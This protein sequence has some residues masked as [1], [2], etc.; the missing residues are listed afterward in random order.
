MNNRAVT[1]LICAFLCFGCSKNEGSLFSNPGPE[2]TGVD[3]ENTLTE[4]DELNILDYLYLYNGGGVAVG[5]INN[6]DLPDIFLTGN[7]VKNKLYLN[8][9]ELQFEDISDTAGIGGNSSWNTGAVMGDVNG[10][11][12]LDIYVCA[13]VGINGFNG[14]NELYINNGDATF[15]ESAA[16]YGLD[17]DS[18]SSSA[19]FLDYD[20]DG[21]LDMYLLN[22]AVHNQES[23][24]KAEIRNKRDYQTGD[25][26]LRNDGGKFVDVSK[27]AGI[28][29]GINSYG[30][31]VAV[32]DFNQDG[33][34]DIYVGNDF[35]EDDYYYLNNGD[36]TF[37]ESL[38][39]YFGHTTRFSMGNDVAD[40]N[41]DGFPDLISLDMLPDDEKVLKASESAGTIQTQRLRTDV[42]GYHYQFPRNM[43]FINRADNSFA[44]SA[45]LSGISA[46]DWS[47]SALFADYD[48][49]GEQ[50]L[51]VSNGILKRP[52]DLDYINFVSSDQIQKKINKTKLVDQEALSLMPSGAVA[53]RIFKGSKNLSFEDKSGDWITHDTI[54]SGAT[55]LAD[56]DLDGDLDLVTNNSNAP[57]SLY[58]NRT[59]DQANF[60]KIKF[61]YHSPNTLGI[62]TKVFSYSDNKLQYKE[63]FTSRGFQAS[64]EPMLHFGYAKTKVI[65]SIRI[66]W[67]DNT[68]Q[69][70]LNINTNQ[71]LKVSP[72]NT[73]P[74]DYQL[75]KPKKTLMFAK[76]ANNLGIDFK[77]VEDGYS[78]FNRQLLMPYQVGDRGP[79]TAVGD[80]DG[81][82]KEDI[83]FGGSKFIPSRVYLQR[84]SSYVEKRYDLIANDS[85][86]EDVAALI[87]DFNKD[88]KND[89]L[90]GTG[91][92]DFYSQ[93]KPLL[94][95]YYV[96]KNDVFGQGVI[97]D[98]FE[99]ASVLAP[100]DFDQ[101]GDLDV[102][103]GNQMLANDYGK[104]PNSYL[105]Q[106]D[107]GNFTIIENSAIRNVGMVT[108]ALWHDLDADGVDDLIVIG[109][110][111][112]PKFFLNKKGKLIETD[113]LND[114]LFGLWQS[115]VPFDM[116]AD[117]DIDF[118][119]GNW[120][121]NTQYKA[122]KEFPL[123]MFY[124]DFD[125]NGATET[126]VALNKDDKYY[127]IE[128]LD[129]LSKQMPGLRKKFPSYKK[130][131]GQPISSIFEASVLN[132]AKE[133]NVTELRSGF[134]E[135]TNG[136]F[137]F[138]PF[139]NDLQL[140]P[141]TSLLVY[142]FDGDTKHEVMAA[143]NY[144]GV[145]PYHGRFD[146]F[147]GALINSEKDVILG[148]R[149]GL[150]MALKSARNLRIISMAG[151]SFLLVTFNNEKAQVYALLKHAKK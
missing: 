72:E 26:L 97:P 108:D 32:S 1:Y 4:S 15:T 65:D 127:P 149:L 70:L 41:H 109:E 73:K 91:G 25:K 61:A 85:I 39:T 34:P 66:I 75:L 74:Y 22:H 77:H 30:L 144:F 145:K 8:M 116:D 98:Y 33:L 133:F 147:S 102:F 111:M 136:K 42:Y 62:G 151:K 129:A 52:N 21:D 76:V 51:F 47:W 117:G 63:L 49:D 110:W 107:N 19:A 99:N 148:H 131:A 141:I 27:E 82:G 90:V 125:E 35:H 120:G 71:T 83:Y 38:R 12:L 46:T 67:P 16:K 29:G 44:E 101:D 55:A 114:T 115:I 140:A 150:D 37:S 105:L 60:L 106:N 126:I 87:Q 59:D 68:S 121:T 53:N 31:G 92:A 23:Y 64:S 79:A 96:N 3:F 113:F 135:N 128:D 7:Q 119:L 14:Y 5:D 123:K 143:G 112:S 100:C 138:R 18:Y 20:A 124:A 95:S 13:V 69:V 84:D 103:V 58:I 130:F 132:K 81:D 93:M 40:I 17:F 104:I 11:G 118:V 56:L 9:G 28:Y 146:S 122:S 24:G 137:T 89:I 142:D 57:A 45:Y 48:Q 134:L 2:Q 6:D 43:L 86:K 78:D 139:N 94:D 36:G 80:L 54:I 10:D 50:D 88:G